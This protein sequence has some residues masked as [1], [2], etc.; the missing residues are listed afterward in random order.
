MYGG[1]TLDRE[2]S[3]YIVRVVLQDREVKAALSR[4]IKEEAATVN[5]KYPQYSRQSFD[6]LTSGNV[7]LQYRLAQN[8]QFYG[9]TIMQQLYNTTNENTYK[10]MRNRI[11]YGKMLEQGFRN[12]PGFTLF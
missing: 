9:N 1:I 5:N 6:D 8:G 3:E 11:R 2:I 10:K 7:N 12:R 4:Q